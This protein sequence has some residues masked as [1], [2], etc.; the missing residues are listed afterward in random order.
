MAA[1]FY[2]VVFGER[3]DHGGASVNLADAV[4]DDFR[5][6]VVHLY[7]AVDF[8]DAAFEAADVADIFQ[9]VGKDDD[10]EGASGFVFAEVD[11][12][13]AFASGFYAQN[14]AGD[15]LDFAD[16]M[17]G[18]VDGDA[19]GG[20]EERGREQ[21]G[22]QGSEPEHKLILW[23]AEERVC[24]AREIN[25]AIVLEWNCG[26]T[27][28]EIPAQAKLGRGTLGVLEVCAT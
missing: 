1:V 9:V 24:D 18:F 16:V 28:T 10:R 4:E 14:L 5:A 3:G 13:D 26:E 6:A 11:E 20:G 23:S 8:D 25:G 2:I 7:G 12:V 22:E 21:Y 19:V 17:A 27:S 15:A